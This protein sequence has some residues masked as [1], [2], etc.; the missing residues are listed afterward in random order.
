MGLTQFGKINWLPIN[1]RFEQYIS[2]MS[3][4]YFNYLSILYLNDVFKLAYQKTTTTRT[5]LFKLSQ[6]LTNNHGQ[7]SISYVAPSLWDKLPDFSKTTNN[8]N[9]YKH[10]VKKHFFQRMNNEEGNIYSYF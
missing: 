8:V 7:K 4:K 1:Y 9:T 2:S 10:R 5:S 3:F 6:T